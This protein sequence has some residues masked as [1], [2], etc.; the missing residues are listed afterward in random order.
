ML[1]RAAHASTCALFFRSCGIESAC[2][3][4]LR[5]AHAYA[6]ALLLAC[7]RR[8]RVRSVARAAHAFACTAPLRVRVEGLMRASIARAAFCSAPLMRLRVLF[9][10]RVRVESA[11]G[12]CPRRPCVCM[13]LFLCVCALRARAVCALPLMRASRTRAAFCSATLMR[14]RVLFL[15]LMRASRARAVCCSAPLM[16]LRS[17]LWL[18]RASRARAAVAP[19]RSCVCVCSSPCVSGLLLRTRLW[20]VIASITRD[21]RAS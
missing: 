17:S 2:G 21:A 7:S 19:R 13:Y 15:W 18:M 9:S 10:L 5:A 3:L 8:E 12:C 14:L 20:A 4:L 6:C 11:C 1:P 16:C